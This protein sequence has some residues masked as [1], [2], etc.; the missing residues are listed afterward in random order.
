VI[1]NEWAKDERSWQRELVRREL[2]GK[3]RRVKVEYIS[4]QGAH[5]T[6]CY[7]GATILRSDEKE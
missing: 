6:V 1:L 3:L 2:Q 4:A 5:R 7:F